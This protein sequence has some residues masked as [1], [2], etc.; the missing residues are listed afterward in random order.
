MSLNDAVATLL[1]VALAVF[2]IFRKTG[3][4]GPPIAW[5]VLVGVSCAH[6]LQLPPDAL[7][8]KEIVEKREQLVAEFERGPNWQKA[9]QTNR[10][11]LIAA[12]GSKCPVGRVMFNATRVGEVLGCVRWRRAR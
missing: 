6:H 9:Y 3:K 1:I 4:G 2:L 10:L 8:M 5:A 11:W 7:S 12:D